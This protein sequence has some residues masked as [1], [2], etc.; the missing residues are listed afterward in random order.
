MTIEKGKYEGWIWYSDQNKPEI[1]TTEKEMN[2]LTL[3]NG[4]NP[5]VIEGQLWNNETMT[6]ISIKYVDGEYIV[7][8]HEVAAEDFDTNKSLV[9]K[10]QFISHKMNGRIIKMLQYWR[11]E[12]DK[13]NFCLGFPTLQP[14][15]IVFVGFNKKK[16]EE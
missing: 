8:Q 10:K 12:E 16:E 5:F 11:P 2:E 13:D 4:E 9:T 15:K 7:K 1:I 3:T 6:S 14:E